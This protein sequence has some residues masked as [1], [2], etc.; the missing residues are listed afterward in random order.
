M[1][2]VIASTFLSL[3]GIMQE[4]GGPDED[5]SDGFAL[6]GW[7]F[8]FFDE[9]GGAFMGELFAAPFDLLLGRRTYDIFAAHW[10]KADESDDDGIAY[11]FNR[12]TKYVATRTLT[13]LDWDYSIALRNAVSGVAELK[14]QDGPDLLIQGSGTLIRDLLGAG[15]IDRFTVMTFPV[16]LGEGK[17]LFGPETG[18]SSLKLVDS[19]TTPSGVAI[20]S[21]EPDG[22][23][24]T[25][26]FA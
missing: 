24:K 6:G 3:D 26:S 9:A 16:L 14:K 8:P 19:R 1:R 10:P 7:T 20:N 5:T 25:G 15:L 2:K 22:A 23:V 21:Y 11:R 17:R 13:T 4:P 18:S 12:A